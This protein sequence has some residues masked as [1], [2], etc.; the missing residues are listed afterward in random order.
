MGKTM[1]QISDID[2]CFFF[3]AAEMAGHASYFVMQFGRHLTDDCYS[4]VWVTDH[5]AVQLIVHYKIASNFALYPLW[6][7]IHFDLWSGCKSRMEERAWIPAESTK[8]HLPVHFRLPS[9][10]NGILV[11]LSSVPPCLTYNLLFCWIV[12]QR[13]C[14]WLSTC[15][16]K[17]EWQ[18][19]G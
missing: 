19:M 5:S 13:S 4:V 9:V 6:L 12:I 18:T 2:W 17:S 14:H 7:G 3:C 10:C 8:T 11:W 15:E 1:V 16:C